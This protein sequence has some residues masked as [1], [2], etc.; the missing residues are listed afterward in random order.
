MRRIMITIKLV[1]YEKLED[2]AN[3]IQF[4]HEENSIIK[5]QENR[6]RPMR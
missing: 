5:E 2:R 3:R 4:H 1:E 6:L